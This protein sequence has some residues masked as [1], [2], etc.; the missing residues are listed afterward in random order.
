MPPRPT[1]FDKVLVANRGEI[2][3]RVMRTLAA[4]GIKSVAVYADSD[5]D[6]AFLDHADECIGLGGETSQQSYLV[7]EKI[8]EACKNTG[9]QAIHPGYGFL[10]ENAEFADACADHNITFIGPSAEVMRTMGNKTLARQTM[11]KA[12]VPVVP[13]VNLEP[14]A[15][16]AEELMR[17]GDQVGFPLL[18]KASFGGGGKGMRR[19]LNRNELPDA[20]QRA[21]SE[22]QNAFGK[23]DVYLEREI[24]RGRHVEVQVLCDMHGNCIHL[25]ERDCS[26]QRRHQK[27]IEETASPARMRHHD[28]ID[29]LCAVGQ[30]AAAAVGYTSAGTVE[31]IFSEE[32]G[33]FFFLEMN[34]RLQ[35]EHPITEWVTG[36]D[37]VHEQVRIAM[38]ERLGRSQKDIRHHGHAIECRLY[39]ED[40]DQGFQ[41]SPGKV[42][43]WAPAE[44][45]RVRVDAALTHHGVI[46]TFFDPMIAKLSVWGENREVACQNMLQALRETKALGI[47][48]NRDFLIRLLTSESFQQGTYEIKSIE[49]GLAKAADAPRSSPYDIALAAAVTAVAEKSATPQSPGDPMRSTLTPWQQIFST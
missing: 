46:P 7:G 16:S 14:R 26:M 30:K 27:V 12:G 33:E 39:A 8:F 45:P 29:A 28:A 44:G 25:G 6:G 35:V 1:S 36:L 19:I 3:I 18:I 34:T 13:G 31:F 49:N 38:G 47:T 21:Q 5:K 2:A 23:G 4:M 41:P 32:T 37:L 22:A 10:S 11:Q 24:Q 40:A 15:Y 42:A 43:F 9:A 17:A 20:L 48:T